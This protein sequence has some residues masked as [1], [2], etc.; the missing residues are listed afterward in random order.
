VVESLFVRTA[1][2][3]GHYFLKFNET[4]KDFWGVDLDVGCRFAR[5]SNNL[6]AVGDFADGGK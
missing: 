4:G 1:S 6:V 3:G 5:R 2:T